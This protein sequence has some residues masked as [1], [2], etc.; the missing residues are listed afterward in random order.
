[1]V[2]YKSSRIFEN[3]PTGKSNH[4]TEKTPKGTFVASDKPENHTT[5]GKGE[6]KKGEQGERKEEKRKSNGCTLSFY[7][8]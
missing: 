8:G 1:M 5:E 7:T 2:K 4:F 6:G 3:V